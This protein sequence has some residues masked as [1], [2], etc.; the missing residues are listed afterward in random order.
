MLQNLVM[1]DPKTDRTYV[2]C[3]AP[4]QVQDHQPTVGE[5][6]YHEPETDLPAGIICLQIIGMFF[7][8]AKVNRSIS[9]T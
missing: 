8:I 3:D 7:S 4:Y 9:Q 2:C 1:A 5:Q 6:W